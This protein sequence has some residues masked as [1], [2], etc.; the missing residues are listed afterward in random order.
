M[1][2][3]QNCKIYAQRK[4]AS[5]TFITSMT[6]ILK[7]S[8]LDKN[9]IKRHDFKTQTLI[10]I[11]KNNKEPKDFKWYNYKEFYDLEKNKSKK[12]KKKQKIENQNAL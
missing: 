9:S 7:D 8:E 10:N 5:K 11:A 4:P 3:F 12:D 6:K 1:I 2:C